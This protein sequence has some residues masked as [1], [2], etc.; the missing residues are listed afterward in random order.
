MVRAVVLT[1][2]RVFVMYPHLPFPP[3]LPSHPPFFF[4]TAQN[5]LPA[6]FSIS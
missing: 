3:L 4:F 5:V 1:D 6:H 2:P